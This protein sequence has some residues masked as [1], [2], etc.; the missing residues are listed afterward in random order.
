MEWPEWYKDKDCNSCKTPEPVLCF[1]DVA[2]I[3]AVFTIK[4]PLDDVST[5]LKAK[6]VYE[7]IKDA[8]YKQSRVYPKMW[9]DDYD[10]L[11]KE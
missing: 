8:L 1:E 10:K 6:I 2:K 4:N 5:P 9:I 3:V 7:E 11:T